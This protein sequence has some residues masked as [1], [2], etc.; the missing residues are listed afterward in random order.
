LAVLTNF[1][2]AFRVLSGF[3]PGLCLGVQLDYLLGK[4][5]AAGIFN[6]DRPKSNAVWKVFDSGQRICGALSL[7][8]KRSG[9]VA[10]FGVIDN[11]SKKWK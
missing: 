8:S 6:Q 11:W 5:N 1:A 9:H 3:E 4:S 2:P 10:C 7:H